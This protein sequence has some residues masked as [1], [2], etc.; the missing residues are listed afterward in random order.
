MDTQNTEAKRLYL[1][2]PIEGCCCPMPEE[3]NDLTLTPQPLSF[4]SE[5]N[6]FDFSDALS[7]KQLE[8][9]HALKLSDGIAQLQTVVRVK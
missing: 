3:G 9:G 6:G 8:L 1:L 7:I 4:F 2:V 5:G